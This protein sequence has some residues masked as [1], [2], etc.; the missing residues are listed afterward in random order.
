MVRETRRWP[1]CLLIPLCRDVVTSASSQCQRKSRRT[2]FCH[3]CMEISSSI[4]VHKLLP[5][6]RCGIPAREYPRRV[7]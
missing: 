6:Q 2:Y 5:R 3:G 1:F 7:L 4:G